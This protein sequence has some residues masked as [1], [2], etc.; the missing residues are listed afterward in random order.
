[1]NVEQLDIIAA[2]YLTKTSISSELC[3]GGEFEVVSFRK[4][5]DCT[6]DGRILFQILID[7]TRDLSSI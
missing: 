3:V 1:M 4:T 7:C 6:V 2:A 5:V